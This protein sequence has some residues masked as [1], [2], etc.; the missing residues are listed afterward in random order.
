MNK[1]AFKPEQ[2][3]S[4]SCNRQ[5][6]KFD[7]NQNNKSQVALNSVSKLEG[8]YLCTD[9]RKGLRFVVSHA[10]MACDLV[11]RRHPQVLDFAPMSLDYQSR[12]DNPIVKKEKF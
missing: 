12:G 6:K 1:M 11:N 5:M 8:L 4:W 3:F 10:I 7:F 2:F 9:L